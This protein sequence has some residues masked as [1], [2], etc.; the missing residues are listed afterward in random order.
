MPLFRFVCDSC[1][2]EKKKLVPRAAAFLCSAC[3][4]GQ[5]QPQLPTDIATQT[6]ERKDPLRG[7]SL[8]RGHAQ[9]MKTRMN[10]HHDKYEIERKI[11]EFGMDDAQRLGW[12]K[13]VKR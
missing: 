9:S 6:M 13:K 2:L 1:G 11:D 7:T 12:T 8:P 4:D 3:V 10:Q 5:M